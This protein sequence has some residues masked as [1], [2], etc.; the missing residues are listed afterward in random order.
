MKGLKHKVAIVAG[1]APGNIG[2]RQP[3]ASLR[4]ARPCWLRI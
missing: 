2:G 4:R 1:A 3:S